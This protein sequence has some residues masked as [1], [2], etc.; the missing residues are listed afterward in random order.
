M[1]QG[2]YKEQKQNLAMQTQ[3]TTKQKRVQ[4]PASTT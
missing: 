2:S 3:T 4:H 1:Q